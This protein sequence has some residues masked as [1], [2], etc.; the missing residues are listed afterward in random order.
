MTHNG[1]LR[2]DGRVLRDMYLFQVKKPEESKGEWDLYNLIETIPAAQ[3]FRPM[4]EGG[5]PLVK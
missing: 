2:P 3:A 1:T 5:C 4:S